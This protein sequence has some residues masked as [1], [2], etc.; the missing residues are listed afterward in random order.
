MFAAWL[1]SRRESL[2][3][4]LLDAIKS[5]HLP[6]E[7]DTE[8]WET[9]AIN[10]NPKPLGH[11]LRTQMVLDLRERAV[12]Y[13]TLSKAVHASLRGVA[14]ACVAA[15]VEELFLGDR[16]RPRHGT[17]RAAVEEPSSS[18]S[19]G[20]KRASVEDT[21]ISAMKRSQS[22]SSLMRVGSCGS[23]V[24]CAELGSSRLMG[25]A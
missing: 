17:K 12:D 23:L 9:A 24:E 25:V 13:A 16:Q 1:P 11:E 2:A 20:T 6:L 21:S 19:T 10:C 18:S 4:V 15:A 14:P 7:S 3:K 22:A 8:F 5:G